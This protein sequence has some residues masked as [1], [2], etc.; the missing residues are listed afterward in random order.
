MVRMRTKGISPAKIGRAIGMAPQFV[1]TATLRVLN[2]DIEKSGE[3]EEVVRDGYW[4]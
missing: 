1:S 3:P 4:K 2:A